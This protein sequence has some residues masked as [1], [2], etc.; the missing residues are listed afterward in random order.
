M[1]FPAR[2]GQAVSIVESLEE[3]TLF[4]APAVTAA[5]AEG[6]LEVVGGKKAD[7]IVI[8]LSSSDPNSVEVQCG[9]FAKVIGSFNRADIPGGIYLSGGGGNDTLVVNSMIDLPATIVGGPGKDI[10]AGAMGDDALDGG[11]GNDTLVGGR[12]DDSLDGGSGKDKLFGG[13][14]DDVLSGGTGN[15]AVTGGSGA[16]AFE[17][18]AAAEVLDHQPD[19]ILVEPVPP[20]ARKH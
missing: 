14:G 1:S 8:I 7:T 2:P 11:P 4:A 6:V 17:D 9:R 15:D 18:D 10:L 5:V 12:G 16:D 13:D 20:V 19:E 3:R